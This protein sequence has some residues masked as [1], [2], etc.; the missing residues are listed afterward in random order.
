MN[1]LLL[2]VFLISMGSGIINPLMGPLIFSDQGFFLT[3]SFELKMQAYVLLMGIYAFG[4]IIGNLVWG[5]ISDKI[6]GKK[7]IIGALIGSIIAYILF[8][9]SL[10]SIIFFLFFIGRLVDGLM[11]G[12]RTVALSMVSLASRDKL[13]SFRYFEIAN[14]L[15]LFF[16]PI[17]CGVLVNFSGQVPL[18][19]YSLPLLIMLIGVVVNIF[20]ILNSNIEKSKSTSK[21]KFKQTFF[22]LPLITCYIAFFILQ[23]AWYLYFL[24]ITPYIIIRWKFTPLGVGLFFSL[25]VFIYIATLLFILP[26]IKKIMG[27]RLVSII[28]LVMGGLGMIL[29]G[30]GTNYYYLF[31]IF[32]I[33]IVMAIA[34]NTPI[35]MTKIVSLKKDHE[36]GKTIGIQNS[37]IGF[38]WLF[39]AF[40]IGYLASSITKLPYLLSGILL[41]FISLAQA[42]NKEA[43]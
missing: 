26:A 24:A 41:M 39:A 28:S 38:A 30:L 5:V 25:L 12:R 34:C 6:G 33:G 31:L 40:I 18:Y 43:N 14:A 37:I 15:G 1:S 9:I 29:T 11:A 16:G 23:L 4:N 22:T 13:K 21:E 20:L 3:S 36:Q 8:F 17:L 27:E 2:V 32:N 7:A 19:Y 42:L 35:Y 10:F